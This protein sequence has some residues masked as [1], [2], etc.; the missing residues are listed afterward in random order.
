MDT[1]DRVT[2]TQAVACFIQIKKKKVHQEGL[3]GSL[4]AAQRFYG[5]GA[6]KGLR[7]L[8]P[9]SECSGE[10][11]NILDAATLFLL[12][13]FFF[14]FILVCRIFLPCNQ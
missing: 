5:E 13:Y 14:R 9:V 11:M 12:H 2:V 7:K 3:N 10:R 1:H 8:Y 4:A 6:S